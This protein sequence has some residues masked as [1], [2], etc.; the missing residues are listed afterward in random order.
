MRTRRERLII[1]G[2]FVLTGTGILYAEEMGYL[3]ENFLK[4]DYQKVIT[5]A[6][7]NRER[8]SPEG[9]Y[10]LGMS[11]LET[12]DSYLARKNLNLL[13]EKYP[14]SEWKESAELAR[15]DCF[16]LDRDFVKAKE[17]YEDFIKRKRKSSLLSLAHF[18][19]AEVKRKQGLWEE[20]KNTYEKISDLFPHSLEAKLS[21]EII[22]GNEF[23]FTLQV[24]SF[25]NKENAYRLMQELE[26]QG[27]SA[28]ISEK[29][30]LGQ[31]YYRVRVGKFLTREESE[32]IKTNLIEL[33][34]TPHLYP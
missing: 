33:G 22:S 11:Y 10:L 24:G 6:E 23:F 19:L 21:Q 8:L 28:Y 29:V 9:Y 31:L 18:K 5:L 3:W 2:V 4:G 13:L 25:I 17:V 27:F 34:H 12:G 32:K 1:F 7:K 30:K 26:S 15:G 20:A 16:L 14:H